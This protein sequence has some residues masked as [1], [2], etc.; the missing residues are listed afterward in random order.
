[1]AV[2]LTTVVPSWLTVVIDTSARVDAVLLA[3][4]VDGRGGGERVARPHLAH[5]PHAV[6]RDAADVEPVGDDASGHA[7]RE[8]AV[9][10][11]AGVAGDLA[12]EHLVA[13]QRVVVARRAR[14]HHDLG[15]GEIVDEQE[16]LRV[17]HVQGRGADAHFG[18]SV[19]TATVRAVTT[20]S[21]CSSRYSVMS[22]VNFNVPERPCFSHCS[23][24][25][26]RAC[27]TSPTTS[28]RWYS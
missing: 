15:A 21:S 24:V 9:G 4:G 12:G 22:S 8:H 2:P 5:E 10:E 11:D 18:P 13:V 16:L 17:A 20:T 6:L 7:H 14:V 26:P 23:P 27:S 3:D 28:G 1:M 25:R 19:S